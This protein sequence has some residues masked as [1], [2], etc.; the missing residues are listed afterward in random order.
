M[1]QR[2]FSSFCRASLLMPSFKGVRFLLVN[3]FH[4]PLQIPTASCM[5][6]DIPPR[7]KPRPVLMS[8]MTSSH[9]RQV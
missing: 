4:F 2:K 1:C 6:W 7:R 9:L 5:I 3:L 8:L